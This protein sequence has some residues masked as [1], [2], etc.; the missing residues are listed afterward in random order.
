MLTQVNCFVS[1]LSL[2]ESSAV[3]SPAFSLTI[4]DLK[5]S[6]FVLL[7]ALKGD[8]KNEEKVVLFK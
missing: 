8:V 6:C 2:L 7:N 4:L 5:C 1:S 3:E